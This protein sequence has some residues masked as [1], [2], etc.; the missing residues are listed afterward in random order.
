MADP[1]IPVRGH[2]LPHEIENVLACME[3][4]QPPPLDPPLD[5]SDN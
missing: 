5:M 4:T 3:H 1:G 2:R